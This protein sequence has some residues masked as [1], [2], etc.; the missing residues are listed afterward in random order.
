M[1]PTAKPAAGARLGA[2]GHIDVD[3]VTKRF[4]AARGRGSQDVVALRDTSFQVRRGEFVSVV[5]P[6]GCG[7]TT[8][9]RMIAGLSPIET[10][11]ILIDDR[12]ITGPGPDRAVVFQHPSLLPWATVVDN[13]AFGLRLRRVPKSTRVTRAH[14]LAALVGLTGFENHLPGQ[15]SGGM[16]QR[17]GL[18]R[19]LA[20]DPQILLLDEP[21]GALDEITRRQMQDELLRIWSGTGVTSLLITHSVDEAILLSDRILVMSGR[22]GRVIEEISVGMSRPRERG[23]ETTQEFVELRHRIWELLSAPVGVATNADE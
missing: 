5:G 10:G 18:A 19:A 1:N 16:Q 3:G 14:E 23:M 11:R 2:R 12:P 20:V 7:K 15:L 22:P 13:I 17:V 6:S 21:F 9:L 4:V 8:L